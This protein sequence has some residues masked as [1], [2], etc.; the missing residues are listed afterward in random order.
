MRIVIAQFF[1]GYYGK[2]SGYYNGR[3]E[4]TNQDFL[5]LVLDYDDEKKLM[6]L[7]QRNYF[8]KD[9]KVTIFGPKEEFDFT[10]EEIYDED[11][12]KIGIVRHPKQIVYIKVPKMVAKDYM[13]KKPLDKI[14][15]V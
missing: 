1:D 6:K 4:I 8:E 7:E 5:G 3:M 11:M 14:K 9:D 13:M 10:V 15:N 2:D 12:Q